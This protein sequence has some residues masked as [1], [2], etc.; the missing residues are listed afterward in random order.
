MGRFVMSDVW[1]LLKL[2]SNLT[3]SYKQILNRSLQP[4]L[5]A[6]TIFKMNLDQRKDAKKM[7]T[8]QGFIVNGDTHKQK[9]EDDSWEVQI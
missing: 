9:L 5:E 3:S 8:Q 4:K 1:E 7:E 2:L 6:L